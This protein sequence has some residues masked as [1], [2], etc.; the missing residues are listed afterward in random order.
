MKGTGPERLYPAPFGRGPFR[1]RSAV[2]AAVNLQLPA[3]PWLLFRLINLAA[4]VA[5]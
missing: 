1:R 3:D 2:V 5:L 4:D